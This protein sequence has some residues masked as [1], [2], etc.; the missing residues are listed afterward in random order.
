MSNWKVT[1]IIRG[2]LSRMLLQK[3]YCVNMRVSNLLQDDLSFVQWFWGG[4]E[5]RI[6]LR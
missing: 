5:Q 6:S 2:D 4:W 3:N 1:F